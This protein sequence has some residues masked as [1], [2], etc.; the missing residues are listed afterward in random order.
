[1]AESMEQKLAHLKKVAEQRTAEKLHQAEERQQQLDLNT[2][3]ETPPGSIPTQTRQTGKSARA[4][5]R[6]TREA[7]VR[8]ANEVGIEQ[9]ELWPGKE[10]PTLFT[11][12]PLFRP[13][14][15]NRA[16]EQQAEA[17][18]TSDFVRLSSRWERG[19][20]WR[21]SPALTVF[22]EDTLAGLMQL[23]N[24]EFKG[25]ELLM[26]SKKRS[27]RTELFISNGRKVTVHSV[28]CVV[29]ELESL[30]RGK[31][32]PKKGW[33]GKTIK[34][35]RESIERLA[36]TTLRFEQPKGLDLYRGKLIPI[37]EVDWV[38]DPRNACYYV[39][40]HPAIVHWLNEY[41][42]FIDLDI[43]RQLTPFGKALH[44]FLASQVS[45]ANYQIDF[46]VLLE[47]I[48]FEGRVSEAKKS[49][50]SQLKKLLD[51]GFAEGF[52]FE[53]NGR[54]VPFKLIIGFRSRGRVGG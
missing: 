7:L 53:G 48:G 28:F 14:Q 42:T 43:R 10:Y 2:A 44:R 11:R 24:I 22:D 16:R 51:L 34:L 5:R 23:R 29:S 18:K 26:P 52:D 15:R 32:P 54:S 1:M 41:Y 12:L 3:T 6:E 38:G 17:T 25:N 19:G 31:E 8:Y 13:M 46:E 4:I 50:I 9:G 39:Q 40:F 21:S 37:I 27:E 20:V 47:A 33:G 49:A 30:I 45:N 35:R 36:A